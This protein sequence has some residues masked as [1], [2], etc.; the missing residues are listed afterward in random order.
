MLSQGPAEATESDATRAIFRML[1]ASF[2]KLVEARKRM[3]GP[4][5]LEAADKVEMLLVKI[6]ELVSETQEANALAFHPFLGPFLDLALNVAHS[7]FSSDFNGPHPP[8]PSVPRLCLRYLSNVISES[9]YQLPNRPVEV[10]HPMTG[11]S[12]VIP[13]SSGSPSDAGD[14]ITIRGAILDDGRV[15]VKSN[16][17][18]V[19]VTKEELRGASETVRN[20]FSAPRVERLAQVLVDMYLRM[21]KDDVESWEDNAEQFL[22]EEVRQDLLI[23]LAQYFTGVT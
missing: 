6:M 8:L 7:A 9:I 13:P 12:V 1:H 2:G 19:V 23:D 15:R 11:A 4:L 16:N 22:I 14:P 5:D 10:V 20:F 18:D 17:G 21:S 3:P